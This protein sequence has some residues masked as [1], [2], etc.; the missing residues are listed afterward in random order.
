VLLKEFPANVN[1]KGRCG[2]K[3]RATETARTVTERRRQ[4][5]V[6]VFCESPVAIDCA[7]GENLSVV[8]IVRGTLLAKKSC[9]FLVSE[10]E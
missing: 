4:R 7:F 6:P 2:S 8:Y 10:E 1:G 3:T 5:G 9:K